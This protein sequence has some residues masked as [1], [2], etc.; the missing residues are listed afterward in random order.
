MQT[1]PIPPP[2]PRLPPVASGPIAG[3]LDDYVRAET[4]RAVFR[5]AAFAPL[6]SL[7]TAG[8]VLVGLWRV[9]PRGRLLLWL[10]AIV[11]LS[12]ARLAVLL[13]Y[14]RRPPPTSQLIRWERAFLYTLVGI[15][16]GWGGGAL[17]IM[18]DSV[19]HEALIYFFLIGIAGSTI[20]SYSAYSTACLLAIT[21]LLV[22]VTVWFAWHDV[23]ELQVMALGGA[24][25]LIAAIRATRTY[26]DFWRRSFR[27]SWEIHEAHRLAD[28]LARTD[29]LTGVSNRRAFMERGHHALEQARRYDRPLALV[30]LDIDRFKAINDTHGHAAGDRVLQAV[31]SLIQRAARTSDIPGRIGG[32]EFA[33]LLP[34]TDER[35]A[36]ALAERL[37]RDLAAVAVSHDGATIRFTCSFGVATRAPDVAVLDALLD[38]A[39]AAMYRAKSEGRNR[40]VSANAPTAAP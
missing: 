21:G 26:G 15:S 5:L 2:P 33:V 12:F 13:A 24:I 25:Y 9:T 7:F 19:T 28:T 20:A 23:R 6:V 29:E 39:D 10:G 8:L 34:E 32:E 31:G 14:K 16:L 30:M 40:V 37:R 11:L 1:A 27:L 22:P 4:L 17:L 18:P 35:E 38:R 3:S 36:M